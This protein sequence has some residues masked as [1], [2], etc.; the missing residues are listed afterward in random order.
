MWFKANVIRGGYHNLMLHD[1]SALT[2]KCLSGD[3]LLI[4]L[5]AAV[6]VLN[7]TIVT[8]PQARAHIL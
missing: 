6:E 5:D 1:R 7:V 3:S 8:D 4:L 2:L